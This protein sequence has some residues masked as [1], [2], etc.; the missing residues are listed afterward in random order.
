MNTRQLSLTV[1]GT[2][3]LSISGALVINEVQAQR[4]C[5]V[6]DNAPVADHVAACGNGLRCLAG[7]CNLPPPVWNAQVLGGVQTGASFDVAQSSRVRGD[8]TVGTAEGGGSGALLVNAIY[9]RLG[10]AAADTLWLGG[11]NNTIRIQGRLVVDN[12]FTIGA[13][14]CTASKVL[15]RNVT[16][17]A[18]ICGDDIVGGP[19]GG[20]G[21]GDSCTVNLVRGVSAATATGRAGGYGGANGRCPA[22]QHVCTSEEVLHTL[23]CLRTNPATVI[24]ADD[25]TGWVSG[26]PPGDIAP[27]NDCNGWA[28]DA[29]TV[30]GRVWTFTNAGEFEGGFGSLRNCDS[31]LPFLCCG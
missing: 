7:R 19:G 21:A 11:V 15:K 29:G 10:Q 16:G 1:I 4:A 24:P 26:G 28:S 25:T 27:A 13:V 20:G 22:T 23:N 17:T 5:A 2:L 8:L 30:L 6:A 31:T 12:D 3:L 14:A 18:W 9:S